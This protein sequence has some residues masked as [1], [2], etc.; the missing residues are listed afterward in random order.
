MFKMNLVI[1]SAVQRD[2]G[3]DPVRSEADPADL[4]HGAG[5]RGAYSKRLP[6]IRDGRR[7]PHRQVQQGP[8]EDRQVNRIRSVVHCV[9]FELAIL[10][11]PRFN[12]PF[13]LDFLVIVVSMH[14]FCFVLNSLSPSTYYIRP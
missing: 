4:L 10:D 13:F 6:T 1:G 11:L 3:R 7:S 9:L 14:Q 2:K 5:D 8:S 12:F